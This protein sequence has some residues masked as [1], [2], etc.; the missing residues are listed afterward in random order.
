[1]Y[2]S[3]IV[4]CSVSEWIEVKCPE[5]RTATRLPRDPAS[6]Y[7]HYGSMYESG[8]RATEAA[9]E[10]LIPKLSPNDTLKIVAGDFKRY[11]VGERSA[12]QTQ[13]EKAVAGLQDNPCNDEARQKFQ[14]LIQYVN[15][16]GNYLRKIATAC[17]ETSANLGTMLEEYRRE[18]N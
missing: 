5:E 2:A 13:L 9:L 10:S 18:K 12:V 14:F 6:T 4:G 16:N 17:K 11:L 7:H 8:Y 3:G 1:M 15:F